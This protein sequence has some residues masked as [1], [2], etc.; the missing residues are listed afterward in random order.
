MKE[1]KYT[2]NPPQPEEFEYLYKSTGWDSTIEITEDS[3]KQV[4]KSTW[5]WVSAIHKNKVVGI[6]RLLSDGALYALVCDMIV[7]P[8]YQSNGIGKQILKKLKEK[9]FKE[10]IQKVWLI[11]APGKSDFYEKLG[12][13]SRPDDA[14]GMQLEL[15]R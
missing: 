3:I 13:I 9:C 5:Y 10:N 6:G 7:L 12:F 4:I 8:E 1:I 15:K 2:E 14:P 11:S